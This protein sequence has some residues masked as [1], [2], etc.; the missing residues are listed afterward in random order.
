MADARTDENLVDLE[1]LAMG[2]PII[3]ARIYLDT[4]GDGVLD[5]G[6]DPLLGLTD[7]SGSIQIGPQY[8]GQ[9]LIA[10]VGNAIDLLAGERLEAGTI[11]TF[12]APPEGSLVVS[13]LTAVLAKAIEFEASLPRPRSD[14]AVHAEI[15]QKI[16]GNAEI[17]P[18]DIA[19]TAL[20]EPPLNAADPLADKKLAITEASFRIQ[21]L[22]DNFKGGD[23]LSL[24]TRSILDDIALPDAGRE[25]TEAS[26]RLTIGAPF[27]VPDIG[28]LLIEPGKDA[29][30]DQAIWGYVDGYSEGGRKGGTPLAHIRLIDISEGFTLKDAA[31]REY[32]AGMRIS[33][34]RLGNIFLPATDGEKSATITYVVNDGRH[35]SSPKTLIIP[36]VERWSFADDLADQVLWSILQEKRRALY[37]ATEVRYLIDSDQLNLS[38]EDLLSFDPRFL[39][40]YL[41]ADEEEDAE[42]ELVDD[43]VVTAMEIVDTATPLIED[44]SDGAADI[45]QPI[46]DGSDGAADIVQP[47]AANIPPSF[48]GTA[49]QQAVRAENSAAPVFDFAATDPQGLTISYRLGG[50]D[51]SAFS[52]DTNGQVAFTGSMDFEAGQTV[53]QVDIFAESDSGIGLG[54]LDFTLTDVNEAPALAAPLADTIFN[55]RQSGTVLNLANAFSDPDAGDTLSYAA[56]LSGGGALPAWLSLNAATGILSSSGAMAIADLGQSFTIDITATDASGLSTTDSVVITSELSAAQLQVLNKIYIVMA[57][58]RPNRHPT[59]LN[60]KA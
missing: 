56:I 47:E 5:I 4:D 54:G 25:M 11:Y 36:T 12:I 28:D 42:P 19:N 57:M 30:L 23:Q 55:Y 34:E 14:D 48:N 38:L 18:T 35:D 44:G 33:A 31:G 53:F 17:T 13:P 51:A 32:T 2:G 6:S 22:M 40:A 10:D 50:A 58:Q 20:Y 24:A 60:S 26:N 8:A 39:A 1:P 27:A 59:S 37:E 9:S 15:L 21:N 16:F 43:L 7:Q 46:E 49:R 3:G 45:I 29:L 41:S 52:I